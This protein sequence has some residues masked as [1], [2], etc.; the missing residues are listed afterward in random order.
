[1]DDVRTVEPLERGPRGNDPGPPPE[2]MFLSP[3]Q[4]I[5][6]DDYQRDLSKASYRQ[7]KKMAAAWDWSSFKAPNVARTDDPERFEIIDGQHTAIAAAT[8]GNV[9]FLPCLVMSAATLAE[10]AKGFL[11]INQDRLALTRI[12]IYNAQIAA[13]D[14]SAIAVECALSATGCRLLAVP[15][16]TGKYAVGDTMAIGTLLDIARR[17]GGGRVEMLLGVLVGAG[18]APVSSISLKAL[19]IA[20]PK[21]AQADMLNRVMVVIRGQG[22]GRL[23]LI[24]KSKTAQGRRSYE[25]LAD[26]L[27]DMAKL[28][29]RRLGRPPAKRG[30]PFAVHSERAA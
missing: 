19:D 11:G 24:A 26:M 20:L 8:N 22:A 4:L 17:F 12:A 14:D 30:R 6:N 25:V 18:A 23:E 27:S 10:K 29:A 15:P 2:I 28:P 13:Q 3:S 16:A 7:I 5:I 9:H 21:D 1:M